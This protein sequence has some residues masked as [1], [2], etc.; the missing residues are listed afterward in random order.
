MT[1]EVGQMQKRKNTQ[2]IL[3]SKLCEFVIKYI[4]VIVYTLDNKQYPYDDCFYSK[5]F[6]I[7]F[8]CGKWEGTD[9]RI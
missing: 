4:F 3:I 8:C 2:F 1:F 5:Q 9:F 6:V 7:L